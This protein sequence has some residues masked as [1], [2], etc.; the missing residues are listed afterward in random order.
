MRRAFFSYP[1]SQQ[2]AK[3]N[4]ILKIADRKKDDKERPNRFQIGRPPMEKAK[5][6]VSFFFFPCMK[7]RI[8][9]QRHVQVAYRVKRHA[10]D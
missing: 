7:Q 2:Q 6:R 4:G 10:Q 1:K 5:R 3:G 9:D 8:R